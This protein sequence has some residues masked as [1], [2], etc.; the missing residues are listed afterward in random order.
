M[1][2]DGYST[3]RVRTGMWALAEEQGKVKT[4]A[5]RRN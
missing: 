5:W 1:Y 2:L 4:G 3:S